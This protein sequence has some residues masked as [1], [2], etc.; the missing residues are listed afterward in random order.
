MTESG[1]QRRPTDKKFPPE[2]FQ[3]IKPETFSYIWSLLPEADTIG[4]DDLAFKPTLKY[5]FT[6]I[7]QILKWDIL[8]AYY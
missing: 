3:S 4:T 8:D 1:I 6:D 5:S 2:L 7:I